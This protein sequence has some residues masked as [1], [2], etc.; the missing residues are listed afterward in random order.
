MIVVQ[1]DGVSK[2]Y[3]VKPVIMEASFQIRAGEKLGLVGRN[4]AGKTTLLRLIAG[5]EDPDSGQVS[6]PKGTRI[7]YVEQN[8]SF[9]SDLSIVEAVYDGFRDLLEMQNALSR[10]S[11]EMAGPEVAGSPERLRRAMSDYAALTEEFER[12]DG[13]SMNSRVTG[14]LSGLGFTKDT[15]QR[16]LRSLSGGERTRVLLARALLS[17]PDVLLLDEPTNHLDIP[18]TVWLEDF[19]SAYPGTVIVVSH[20]RHFLDQVVTRILEIEDHKVNEYAGN[21]ST[22]AEKKEERLSRQET[23][24]KLQQGE[25]A[26]LE[27]VLRRYTALSARNN[28]FARRAEDVRKKLA[29]IERLDKPVLKRKSIGF[30]LSNP[31]RG[32]DQVVRLEDLAM[33][34]GDRVLFSNVRLTVKRGE[35]VGIIGRNGVGKSTLLHVIT[36]RIEPS[37]GAVHLGAGV[38]IG[39]YDQQHEDLAPGR[40]VIEE[41]LSSTRLT[42]QEARNLLGRFMFH[43]DDVFKRIEDLSGGERNR[44]LLARLMASGC[45]LLVMDEPTNHLDIDSVEVLEKVLA[46]YDGTVLVVSHDRYFL[47]RV[48]DRILELEDGRVVDY[49]GGYAYYLEK[50]SGQLGDAGPRAE[51]T[52][53]LRYGPRLAWRE[54]WSGA[55]GERPGVVGS[56]RESRGSR[57]DGGPRL[58]CAGAQQESVGSVEVL[59][60]E[61]MQ[62]EATIKHLNAELADLE[63]YLYPDRMAEK[64][65]S[66]ALAEKMLEE[67]Y[68]K[69][70]SSTNGT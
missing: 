32:G 36:G 40:T 20:D 65:R 60:R 49:P 35:H 5:L 4:G 10:L 7:G 2:S 12:A 45:N 8:P 26:R 24:Y 38:D 47:G 52:S 58:P 61:I 23:A 25:I 44:V 42:P 21:Y 70:E 11:R 48:A 51:G 6:V 59:E 66:L 62:L 43:G 13:Y 68:K 28:K 17:R 57:G 18:S 46:G 56:G 27:A 15:W 3:G 64:A 29:R 16:P 55:D 19:L 33:G 41:V 67:C 30:S 53:A 50:K 39:Y 9:E 34:F 1:M 14:V 54:G 37:A 63:L 69:W 22:Y 31:D